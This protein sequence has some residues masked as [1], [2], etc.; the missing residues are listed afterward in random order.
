M[1]KIPIFFIM[2]WYFKVDIPKLADQELG[3]LFSRIILDYS[4]PI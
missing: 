4:D 2:F 3:I 1:K